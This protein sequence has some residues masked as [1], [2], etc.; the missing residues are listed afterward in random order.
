MGH[1]SP[2]QDA[3][4][5]LLSCSYILMGLRYDKETIRTLFA[6]V[7]KMRESSTYQAILEEGREEGLAKG[8]VVVRQD[9]LLALLEERFGAVPPAVEARVRAATDPAR[10]QAA[11]RQ[12]LRVA[13]PDEIAL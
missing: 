9:D 10:L 4:N 11:L 3:A 2:D 6:G 1:E 13:A 7:Q 5:L 8:Q 12:V